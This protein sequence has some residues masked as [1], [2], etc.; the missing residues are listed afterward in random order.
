MSKY[1]DF[2]SILWLFLIRMAAIF[3]L[4]YSIDHRKF[5]NEKKKN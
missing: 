1:K 2:K 4:F 5:K 3:I